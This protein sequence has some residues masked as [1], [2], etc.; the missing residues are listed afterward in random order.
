M[1]GNVTKIPATIGPKNYKVGIYCRVSSTKK[2]QLL[3]LS[4]QISGLTRFAS[5]HVNYRIKDIYI[6]YESGMYDDRDG[7]KR[8]TAD[9]AAGL[10][11]IVIV[12]SPSRLGRDTV[13]VLNVCEQLKGYGCDVLFQ[14]SDTLYSDGNATLTISITAAVDQAENENRSANTRW[15]IKQGLLNG[16]SG[17]YTRPFFGYRKVG[18]ELL[19]YEDEAIIVRKIYNLYLNGASILKIK[20]ALESQGYKTPTGKD[21]WPKKTIE[22]ILTNRRY[23]GVAEITY[24]D[25]ASDGQPKLVTVIAEN[26]NPPIIDHDI[27]D[28]VQLEMKERSNINIGEDGTKTRKQTRY[29]SRIAEN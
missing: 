14:N 21:V 25:T 29:K 6:D 10:I 5:R 26:N 24:Q 18:D 23:T 22:H 16:T 7:L 19:P 4:N 8:L 13:D 9:A 15:G 11:D 17:L 1:S 2:Q 28:A 12:K 20:E 27:F 3:S